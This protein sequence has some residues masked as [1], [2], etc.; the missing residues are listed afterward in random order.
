M[1]LYMPD[2]EQF[3]IMGL[4]AMYTQVPVLAVASGG[5][6]ETVLEGKTGNLREPARRSGRRSWS[7]CCRTRSCARNS[8]RRGANASPRALLGGLR[9]HLGRLG[10][11]PR[12]VDQGGSRAAQRGGLRM[13][14]CAQP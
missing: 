12:G 13:M 6:L 2:R 4:E 7:A 9:Q 3:G 10:V 14:G 5:P 8:A 11:P 1:M